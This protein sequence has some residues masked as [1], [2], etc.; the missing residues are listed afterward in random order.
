MHTTWFSV[1]LLTTGSLTAQRRLVA[2]MCGAVTSSG[3]PLHLLCSRHVMLHEDLCSQTLEL[4]AALVTDS[5][6]SKVQQ[7]LRMRDAVVPETYCMAPYLQAVGG[8]RQRKRLAQLRTGS[9]W[10]TVESGL[11]RGCCVASRSARLSAVQQRR[12]R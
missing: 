7:Y 2:R 4:S 5:E 3:G 6:S 10:L 8:W 9:H 12:S 11:P 1:T